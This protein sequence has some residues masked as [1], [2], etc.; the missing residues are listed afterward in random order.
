MHTSDVETEGVDG[1]SPAPGL[2]PAVRKSSELV[3]NGVEGG[4]LDGSPRE[5]SGPQRG[6][7]NFLSDHVIYCA[8][9]PTDALSA[10]TWK[11]RWK[12]AGA[13]AQVF[14]DDDRS[15]P[16]RNGRPVCLL[17]EEAR[18]VA[19]S[20][21][22]GQACGQRSSCHSRCACGSRR[23][24][25]ACRSGRRVRVLAAPLTFERYLTM[26]RETRKCLSQSGNGAKGKCSNIT[27]VP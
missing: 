4:P 18:V 25:S 27:S 3:K 6:G 23:S 7:R 24:Q 14:V 26:R 16:G 2:S 1:E 8:V 5:L 20:T 12:E 13:N 22:G 21:A 17:G 10:N 11:C 15:D 19:S 9:D